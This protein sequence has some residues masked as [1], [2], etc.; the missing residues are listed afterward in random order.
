MSKKDNELKYEVIEG[1]E[2]WLDPR[3]KYLQEPWWIEILIKLKILKPKQWYQRK[4]FVSLK[5]LK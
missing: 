3:D 5:D 2:L 1:Y 4:T